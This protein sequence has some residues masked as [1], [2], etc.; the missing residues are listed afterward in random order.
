MGRRHKKHSS[1]GRTHGFMKE[2][3]KQIGEAYCSDWISVLRVSNQA[4]GEKYLA[5]S[6]LEDKI[7]TGDSEYSGLGEVLSSIT[8]EFF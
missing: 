2:K 1:K 8:T 4:R 3:M 5:K 7:I 6:G